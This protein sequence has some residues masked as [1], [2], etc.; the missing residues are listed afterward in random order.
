MPAGVS[1]I[2]WKLIL[3]KRCC[4]KDQQHVRRITNVDKSLENITKREE[5]TQREAH[6]ND[7]KFCCMWGPQW[8]KH[9]SGTWIYINHIPYILWKILICSCPWS[10]FSIS[11]L[12]MLMIF[13]YVGWDLLSCNS[14]GCSAAT[15]NSFLYPLW[16]TKISHIICIDRGNL[17]PLHNYRK[18]HRRLPVI[19]H[20]N[21]HTWTAFW[22]HRNG[23]KNLQRKI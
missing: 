3:Y 8:W 2:W 7:G 12:R 17:R 11:Y 4:K 13:L 23:K 22:T 14:K 18:N 6:T 21:R 16:W 10:C 5:C 19:L 20:L 15:F 9:I 1:A